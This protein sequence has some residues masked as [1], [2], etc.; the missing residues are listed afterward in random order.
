VVAG[1]EWKGNGFLKPH[2]L[3]AE[4]AASLFHL[5]QEE[6]SSASSKNTGEVHTGEVC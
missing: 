3:L 2:A 4:F 5:L 1:E 6:G